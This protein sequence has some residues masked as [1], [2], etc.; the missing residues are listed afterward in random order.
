[1]AL[2]LV[3]LDASLK[4]I[5]VWK[6]T[7]DPT[8]LT[9]WSAQ[10]TGITVGSEI[11]S[12]WATLSGTDIFIAYQRGANGCPD[13]LHEVGTIEYC[14]FSTTTDTWTTKRFWVHDGADGTADGFLA[15][16]EMGV[17]TAVR[18]DGEIVIFCT[19]LD[20]ATEEP[21]TYYFRSDTDFDSM[22]VMSV[23]A[24]R[25]I[26]GVVV[27]G[28]SNRLHFFYFNDTDNDILHRSTADNWSWDTE[29]VVDA[30][31]GASVLHQIGRGISYLDN[32]NTTIK[33][34]YLDADESITSIRIDAS[35]ANPT[36]A[37]DTA[38][39]DNDA[40]DINSSVVACMAIDGTDT[41]LLYSGGGASG[42]DQDIY[43][44][45]Q[46]DGGSWGTDT[47]EQNAVTANRISAA[48]YERSNVTYMGY[49]W[50]NG[51]TVDYDEKSM[52]FETDPSDLTF[53]RQNY[54]LGPW[55]I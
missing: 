16:D 44:D 32:G 13:A 52:T 33:V 12:L 43:S 48:V 39:S 8:T 19:L 11:V 24:E 21:A 18:G 49:V 55:D 4:R 29:A 40:E 38:A 14:L 53:P 2:Y 10:D 37:T 1:M 26:A 20:N 23:Q 28:A 25:N 15:D 7:G 31:V 50:L 45:I 30:A 34:P 27:P 9:N 46:E 36:I 51:S 47:E 22:R 41:Y 54:S 42:V 5:Y 3:G 6:T 35:Q 17:S